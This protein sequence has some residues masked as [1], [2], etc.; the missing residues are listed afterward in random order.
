M[1]FFNQKGFNSNPDAEQEQPFDPVPKV[2]A[3]VPI[4]FK[5]GKGRKAIK[6]RFSLIPSLTHKQS[7]ETVKNTLYFRNSVELPPLQQADL[8][9]TCPKPLSD[10]LNN[11]VF[12]PASKIEQLQINK[13]EQSDEFAIKGTQ[14]LLN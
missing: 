4:I 14:T 3:P 11:A 7:P 5:K 9:L 6:E 2:T 8:L 10:Q 13:I 1:G 12:Q